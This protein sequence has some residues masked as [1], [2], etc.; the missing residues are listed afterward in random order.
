MAGNPPWVNWQSLPEDYR[1]ETKALWVHHGL[2]PHSGMDTI[3]G[4]GKKDISM[5]MTYVALENYLQD[6]GQLGFLIT[7]SVF[8]TAGAG[9]GFRR[10]RLGSGTPLAVVHVDDMAGLKPFAGASNRTSI[11][12]LERGQPT[13]YP[14][15]YTTW[16]KKGGGATIPEDVSLEETDALTVRRHFVAEPVDKDDPTSPWITGRERALKA[17]RR[18]IG[19]SD[20]TAHAGAYTGGANAVYWLE[21]VAHRP[22]GLVIVS[23]V[24]KGAKRKVEQVTMALEPDLLYPLLRGRDVKRW[25]IEPSAYILMV[26]DPVRR[27]GIAEDELKTRLPKTYRYLQ[28]FEG[29]L[30]QRAAYKRYFRKSDPFYSMFN[31]SEYTFAPYKVLWR[32][33]AS[34]F[35]CAVISNIEDDRLGRKLVIPDHR[36][37]IVPFEGS[38]EAYY[39]C[40]MLNSAPSRFLVQI[41]VIGTQISTHVLKN[42]RVSKFNPDN[43]THRALAVLSQQAHEAAAQGDTTRVQEIEAE[44]DA[45][46]AK[47]WGLS[48][49]ELREIR[50]SLEELG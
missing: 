17:V 25:Q 47:V 35:T 23:N 45:L 29:M 11:V 34:E 18:V 32:Y 6:K 4:K 24:T 21:V 30:R 13:K 44:I 38:S 9:Q 1:Q 36:L 7:Q 50:E 20:Y 43:L 33:I 49:A 5:L 16:H 26:Q 46:A 8:K 12:V 28:Q 31:V 40:A 14:V 10:F 19:P 37:I 22:D 2:F 15:P 27:R 42:L 39:L 3:L 48:E 41:Y